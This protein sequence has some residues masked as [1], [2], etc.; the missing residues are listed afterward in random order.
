MLLCPGQIQAGGEW[1]C[2]GIAKVPAPKV[3][4][5]KE[6]FEFVEKQTADMSV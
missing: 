5:S 3:K 6:L 4:K 2:S 1:F